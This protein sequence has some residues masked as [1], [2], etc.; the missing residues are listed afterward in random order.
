VAWFQ[1]RSESPDLDVW[2]PRVA[3]A[4]EG[5]VPGAASRVA[6]RLRAKGGVPPDARVLAELLI[7]EVPEWP[8]NAWLVVDDFH[9]I[10]SGGGEEFFELL[11]RTP[12]QMLVTSRIR[13]K[14]A[15]ARG[16]LYG[17]IHE[18]G[19]DALSM[20]VEEA[21]LVLAERREGAVDLVAE[22]GGWPAI[23]GLAAIAP[24]TVPLRS[25]SRNLDEFFA[26]EVLA[27]C[28]AELRNEVGWLAVPA[29]LD[30][31]TLGAMFG[32]RAKTV[33]EQ[34]ERLGVAA[35]AASGQV[36]MNPLLRSFLRSRFQDGSAPPRELLV[37]VADYLAAAERWDE[38]FA[39]VDAFD[40]GQELLRLLR[41][42]LL[43]LVREGHVATVERWV[44]AARRLGVAD[45]VV[46]LAEAEILFVQGDS[47]L[48]K[49]LALVAADRLEDPELAAEALQCA[50]RAMHY[51]NEYRSSRECFERAYRTTSDSTTKQSARWGQFL[52]TIHADDSDP[53]VSLQAYADAAQGRPHELLRIHAGRLALAARFGGMHEEIGAARS[54]VGLLPRVDDAI[55]RAGFKSSSRDRF[56]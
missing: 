22:A 51:L 26:E 12:V 52:S 28:P 50:G 27:A 30:R 33:L 41:T 6:E 14:W 48:A 21:E 8:R 1:A 40:L 39:V 11:A 3:E 29:Q 7:A 47:G 54:L 43:P 55:A 34:A 37:S 25:A 46:D 56:R 17:E 5:V 4:V 36:E 2:A 15:T 35:Q 18:V 38:S 31:G 9:A 19:S 53:R 44:A 32:D 20:T 42:A 16:V 24:L 10:A 23:V 45:A 49:T 13:P